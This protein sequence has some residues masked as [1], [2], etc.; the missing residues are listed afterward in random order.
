MSSFDSVT[1]TFLELRLFL[2]TSVTCSSQS[3][4]IGVFVK[5]KVHVFFVLPLKKSDLI[6]VQNRFFVALP[7]CIQH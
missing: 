6:G 2:F 5:E 3:S 4:W 7:K 1:V